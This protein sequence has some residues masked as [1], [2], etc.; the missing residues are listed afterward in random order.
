MFC[1]IFE[2]T[3]YVGQQPGDPGLLRLGRPELDVL[4]GHFGVAKTSRDG[5]RH[6]PVVCEESCRQEFLTFK[7]AAVCQRDEC[8]ESGPAGLLEQMFHPSTG[9]Q[10]L[11]RGKCYSFSQFSRRTI[12]VTVVQ[13]CCGDELMC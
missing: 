11:T 5:T 3:S 8:G 1:Q 7:R 9:L 6:E 13:H 2:P 10:T 4:L 12:T